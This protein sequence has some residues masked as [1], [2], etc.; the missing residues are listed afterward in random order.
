[1]AYWTVW[2]PSNG[3]FESLDAINGID[4]LHMSCRVDRC[5]GL[6]WYVMV[7]RANSL[8][9]GTA[10]VQCAW[11]GCLLQLL[12]RATAVAESNTAYE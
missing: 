8:A 2:M 12:A 3:L 10:P 7:G 9:A 6:L 5:I 1:M 11:R 4:C